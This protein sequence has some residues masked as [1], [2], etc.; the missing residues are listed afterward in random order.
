MKIRFAVL[1]ALAGLLAVGSAQAQEAGSA[2]TLVACFPNDGGR[3]RIVQSE[4]DC[5]STESV[6]V[7]NVQGPQGP[8]GPQGPQGDIGPQGPEGPQGPQGAQGPQ[9]VQG[10]QGP[11]GP[12]GPQGEQGP[13]GPQGEPGPQGPTGP[14]GAPG[15]EGQPGTLGLAGK[16]CPSGLAVT[17][18][19]AAGNLV[20]GAPW[21]ADA[22]PPGG[23]GTGE[24]TATVTCADFPPPIEAEAQQLIADTVAAIAAEQLGTQSIPT[25]FGTATVTLTDLSFGAAPAVT[26]AL[27]ESNADQPC[28]DSLTVEALVASVLATGTWEFLGV[29]GTFSIEIVDAR[30]TYLA[31]LDLPPEVFTATV[32]G[33]FARLPLPGS[34]ASFTTA[35]MIVETGVGTGD[36]DV[37]S[38]IGF[39]ANLLASNIAGAVAD[40][41]PATPVDDLLA[42]QP[43]PVVV[44]LTF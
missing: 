31:P 44:T 12:A 33:S 37:S 2:E 21:L 27:H 19:D 13:A 36:T 1:S 18:F 29:P 28:N 43:A 22:P 8:A 20:C 32:D 42:V 5:K 38:V 17:G 10:A 7:W 9:G 35:D 15:P 3:V 40:A 34:L 4:T 41:L 24:I 30:L 11:Q 14:T 6:A 39:L 16:S 25:P 23:T 26:V